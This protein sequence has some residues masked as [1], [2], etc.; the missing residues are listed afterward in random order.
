[1]LPRRYL[2]TDA[3][4]AEVTCTKQSFSIYKKE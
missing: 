2:V 1:L 3:P 4:S